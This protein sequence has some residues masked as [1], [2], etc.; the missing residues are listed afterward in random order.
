MP[1]QALALGEQIG[2]RV[3]DGHE[4]PVFR[5]RADDDCDCDD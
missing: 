1:Q 3:I 4:I 2:T 5:V